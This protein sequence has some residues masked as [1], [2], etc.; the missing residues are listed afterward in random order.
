MTT[1]PDLKAL[2]PQV[3][4]A[5]VAAG[6]AIMEI[7]NSN[8]FGTV[9]KD[10][11]SP[12]TKADLASNKVILE[13]LAKIAPDIPVLSE[14]AKA[15]PYDERKD[16]DFFWLVDPL[17]GTKEFIKRNGEFTVNIALIRGDTPV[18]GVVYAPALKRTYWAAEGQ[19]SFKDEA[20]RIEALDYTGGAVQ[21]VASRSHAGAATEALVENLE[22]DHEVNLVSSGSSLKLCM[23][24]DGEA[25][26]Y[27]RFG[28]TMEWD[29]AAAQ[30]VAEQAGAKVLQP[31]GEPLR[32][33][34][35][36]LLNPYFI[37][38]KSQLLFD[39]AAAIARMGDG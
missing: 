18:L 25:H 9:S 35:E 24:A 29:T 19:G 36:N 39:R 3:V 12:L 14:E 1:P 17:D 33:N 23:V 11:N 8:D 37:V 6:D 28:P 20:T 4:T 7:Y 34:K 5:A 31:N 15:L 22:T 38:A 2:A 21:L 13:H 30:A 26:I 10:D 27:P 32:Y 16:W